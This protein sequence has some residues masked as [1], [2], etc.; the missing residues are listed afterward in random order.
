MHIVQKI[1]LELRGAIASRIANPSLIEPINLFR[2]EEKGIAFKPSMKEA[3]QFST[4]WAHWKLDKSGVLQGQKR[5]LTS[6]DGDGFKGTH[7]GTDPET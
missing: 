7:S 5:K 2:Q 4:S 3:C 6:W 1:F